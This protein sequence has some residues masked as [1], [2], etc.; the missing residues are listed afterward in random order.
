MLCG[1]WLG[2]IVNTLAVET[3]TSL[4]MTFLPIAHEVITIPFEMAVQSLAA[5]L[6][7]IILIKLIHIFLYE[8]SVRVV[9]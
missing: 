1:Y 6:A 8:V 3:G 9:L 2:S 5:I 7:A 4:N